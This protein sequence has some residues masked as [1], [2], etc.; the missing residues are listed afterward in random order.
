MRLANRL[1]GWILLPWRRRRRK[2][3]HFRDLALFSPTFFPLLHKF[4]NAARARARLQFR[5]R[6]DVG[7]HYIA[8]IIIISKT[9]SEP[10]YTL[11]TLRQSG[12][13]NFFLSPHQTRRPRL[14]EL[15]FLFCARELMLR[16]LQFRFHDKCTTI[17]NFNF[18]S[19]HQ[20]SANLQCSELRPEFIASIP[21]LFHII[22]LC[23]FSST[24]SQCLSLWV[25]LSQ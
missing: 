17:Y 25:G 18:S 11:S 2:I 6:T 14:S 15:D 23:L 22:S 3:K 9:D 4:F 7:L 24:E 10:R 19:Q 12:K 5:H 16:F 13:I 21:L 8:I 20:S 1:L